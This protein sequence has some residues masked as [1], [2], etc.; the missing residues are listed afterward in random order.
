MI[1]CL[2]AVQKFIKAVSAQMK[3]GWPESRKKRP[4]C[5]PFINAQEK[6]GWDQAGEK[7][8]RAGP[9]FARI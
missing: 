1:S 4:A 2:S 8:F 3:G 9:I 7:N 5:L 6:R